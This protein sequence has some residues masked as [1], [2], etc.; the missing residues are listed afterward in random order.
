[1]SNDQLFD[2][3]DSTL[4]TNEQKENNEQTQSQP[5]PQSMDSLFF[6]QQPNENLDEE[7]KE[8]NLFGND[9]GSELIQQNENEI[10]LEKFEEDEQEEEEQDE[11]DEEEEDEEEQEEQ[12]NFSNNEQSIG[13]PVLE[14]QQKVQKQIQEQENQSQEEINKLREQAKLDLEKWYEEKNE[15][16]KKIWKENNRKEELYLKEREN[17]YS[18]GQPWEKVTSFVDLGKVEGREKD[19][20]RI[21]SIFLKLKH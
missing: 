21:R 5:Q 19:V 8:E 7:K 11:E 3:L 15:Q 18:T 17:L 13:K 16:S 1:M 20:T 9:E 2:L 6:S 4:Q 12:E 14:W 10:V